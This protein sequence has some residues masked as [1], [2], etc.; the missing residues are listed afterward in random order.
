V[1]LNTT[2][3]TIERAPSELGIT[4]KLSTIGQSMFA[5]TVTRSGEY[6]T[7]VTSR[8]F[9][10]LITTSVCLPLLSGIAMAFLADT[11]R[12]ALHSADLGPNPGAGVVCLLLS[13]TALGIISK[14]GLYRFR[15]W[16]RRM[17]LTL[18]GISLIGF[19]FLPDV[20]AVYDVNFLPTGLS[21]SPDVIDATAYMIEGAILAIAYFAPPIS[22]R[23]SVGV[24]ASDVTLAA[25][26]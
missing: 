17:N 2:Q 10:G 3:K 20:F 6:P 18:V 7:M 8:F 16:A 15:P 13:F 21:R 26:N 25:K 14:I 5:Y 22:E 24:D 9:R 19:I 11:N 4:Q 23:F 1:N 12:T